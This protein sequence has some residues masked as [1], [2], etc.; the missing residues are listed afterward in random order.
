MVKNRKYIFGILAV[1]VM[2]PLLMRA[3]QGNSLKR[4]F[5]IIDGVTVNDDKECRPDAFLS[6][7]AR[8]VISDLFPDILPGYIDRIDVEAIDS[9]G[10]Y[11][12]VKITTTPKR[13]FFVVI[14][15]Y[16]Y[17]LPGMTFGIWLNENERGKY[18][19]KF[20]NDRGLNNNDI[21]T[22]KYLRYRY[23]IGC[24]IPMPTIVLT[25]KHNTK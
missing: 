7:S 15:G 17:E 13:N 24:N 6:D 25:T 9:I 10:D 8:I 3:Q 16:P 19:R 4:T 5:F 18:L 21:A 14:D 23:T 2:L 12:V 22:A 11:N 1:F 20:L